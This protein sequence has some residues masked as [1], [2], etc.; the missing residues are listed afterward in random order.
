MRTL[1]KIL[2][3]TGTK[4]SLSRHLLPA[5]VLGCLG[6]RELHWHFVVH[7]LSTKPQ[8]CLQYFINKGRNVS[9]SVSLVPSTSSMMG[10]VAPA[11][12]SPSPSTIEQ[13]P[14]LS[15][16]EIFRRF[17][18]VPPAPAKVPYQLRNAEATHYSQS[19]QDVK[20]DKLLNGKEGGF[21][22]EVG[23]YDGEIMSNTLFFE[24]TR[25]W[26]GLLIEANPRA[27][28][29]ILTK[30]R[31][32]WV[33]GACIS[34]TPKVE[35]VTFLAHGM[36]GGISKGDK[37]LTGKFD[38]LANKVCAA[39]DAHMPTYTYRAIHKVVKHIAQHQACAQTHTGA[40]T[41]CDWPTQTLQEMQ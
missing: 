9:D 6:F 28:R 21:F 29:E 31:K 11:M 27:Y 4:S 32:A 8:N 34:L 38:G 12:P 1:R 18:L 33:A 10:T 17:V 26:T 30:D 19:S 39:S 5:I 24:K 16:V 37:A 23:A 41:N 15:D 25:K 22:I 3:R 14:R 35:E 20:A 36:I 40:H 13:A 7:E 2:F